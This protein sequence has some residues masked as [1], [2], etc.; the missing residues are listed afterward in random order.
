MSTWVEI[1]KLLL[2]LPF[3]PPYKKA[4]KIYNGECGYVYIDYYTVYGG[5]S[6]STV[7]EVKWS[8][9]CC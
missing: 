6:T 9:S 4:K 3:A 2:A 7:L 5:T 8:H 1:D